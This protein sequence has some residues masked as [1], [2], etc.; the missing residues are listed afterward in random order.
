VEGVAVT[1]WIQA[2]AAVAIVTL[3]F[4]LVRYTR[5][6]VRLTGD[7]AEVARSQ[8]ELIAEERRARRNELQAI[9]ISLRDQVEALFPDRS[10]PK[11]QRLILSDVILARLKSLSAEVGALPAVGAHEIEK[12]VVWLDQRLEGWSRGH[13]FDQ[14]EWAFYR[15]ETLENLDYLLKQMGA[16]PPWS[17]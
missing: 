5:R 6:Y 9:A 17:E 14:E 16:E 13:R 3:T 7:L 10:P 2:A 11:G 8:M 4:F 15:K 1:D 12:G